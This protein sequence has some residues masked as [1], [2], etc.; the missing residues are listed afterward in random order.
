MGK[1]LFGAL[2]TGCAFSLPPGLRERVLVAEK[3][4]EARVGL[5]IVSTKIS[6]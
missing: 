4:G 1:K 2:S 5:R 6:I 3:A